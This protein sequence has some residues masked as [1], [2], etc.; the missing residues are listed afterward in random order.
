[1]SMDQLLETFRTSHKHTALVMDEFG[2]VEGLVT[3]TDLLE[4]LVG[5]LPP[6]VDSYGGGYRY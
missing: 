5:R 2:A 3:I 6:F 4:A 1:M